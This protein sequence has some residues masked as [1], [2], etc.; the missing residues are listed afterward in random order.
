MNIKVRE[1]RDGDIQFILNTWLDH[2]GSL[3]FYK[4]CPRK[5]IR[6]NCLGFIRD[7]ATN[8]N[9]LVA[10][11][12]ESEDQ[13]FSYLV[14]GGSSIYFIYTKL[15]YR[16]MG[17]AN[18]LL[19]QANVQ[20]CQY[21]TGTESRQFMKYAKSNKISFNPWGHIES[22]KLEISGIDQSQAI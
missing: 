7:L 9:V 16:N 18:E 3:R 12:D 2:I 4:K 20:F 10:C 13:I 11:S 1:V 22:K 19:K 8:S 17:I 14:Y 21:T 6:E 5:I 15:I